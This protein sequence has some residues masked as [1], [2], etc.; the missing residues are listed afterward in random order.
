M[1][2]NNITPEQQKQLDAVFDADM[3]LE[4]VRAWKKDLS[5]GDQISP[6]DWMKA[7]TLPE[8]DRTAAKAKRI[9]ESVGAKTMNEFLDDKF[10]K[11]NK[12]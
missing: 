5:E 10:G 12:K 3:S 1:P 11:L 2:E 6:A 8:A 4:D 9:S 7:K